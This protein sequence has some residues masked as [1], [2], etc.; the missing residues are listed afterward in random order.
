MREEEEGRR[1]GRGEED[2]L[3][4]PGGVVKLQLL[5]SFPLT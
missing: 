2:N 3:Q 1:R 5:T 4:G